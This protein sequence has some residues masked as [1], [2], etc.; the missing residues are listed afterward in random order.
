M[1]IQYLFLIPL[2]I[3][4]FRFIK[5]THPLSIGLNILVTTIL[6]AL[7]SGGW[8]T[9]RCWFSYILVLI[10]LG[11]L[12]VIFIYVTLLASNEIF[13]PKSKFRL[14]TLPG[15]F[16]IFYLTYSSKTLS[17]YE[18]RQLNEFRLI[19]NKIYSLD[20]YQFTIFL[21]IYLLLVLL[22]VVF[23]TK[24]EVAPLRRQK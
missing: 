23:N 5:Q 21:A 9:K 7:I 18:P 11:G 19:V 14:L 17:L 6:I 1:D 20:L 13:S 12:L 15:F 16:V 8:R 2:I 22:V 4:I 10:L 24:T 3:I